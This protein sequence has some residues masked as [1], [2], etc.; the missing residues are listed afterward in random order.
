M[1]LFLFLPI[2]GIFI[3]LVLVVFGVLALIIGYLVKVY[4]ERKEKT[5]LV[6]LAF[7]LAYSTERLYAGLGEPRIILT[8]WVVEID[9]GMIIA[10]TALMI[11]IAIMKIRELYLFPP[12]VGTA[13]V[14]V[15][16]VSSF[17]RTT[18][19]NL[20]NC[21]FY[22]AGYNL[23]NPLLDWV[24]F[25]YLRNDYVAVISNPVNVLL[26]PDLS[27]LY[28]IISGL[29]L[30]LP[31]LI[32]FSVIAW[33]ERSGKALGFVLG[34]IIILIGGALSGGHALIY[35]IFEVTGISIIGVGITGLIDKY[36]YKTTE[37]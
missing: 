2:S 1:D 19:V 36:V 18:I 31:T 15:N 34:L 13:L 29:I 12:L 27:Y 14:A 10:A 5:T 32:L 17:Y 20:V 9:L 6:L 21:I 33:R 4:W 28:L 25:R 16:T 23:W 37:T 8:H 11:P 22:L 26:I 30:S 24:N 7:F 3:S 35:I